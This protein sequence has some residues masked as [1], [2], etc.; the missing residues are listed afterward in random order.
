MPDRARHRMGTA[1]PVLGV[2]LASLTLLL[3]LLAAAPASAHAAFVASSPEP[4]AELVSAPG[5]VT[6]RFSEPL[7]DD[8]SSATVTDPAGQ[9]FTSGPS[10]DREIEVD[11]NSTTQGQYTVEWKTVSPIDGHTLRG[12]FSFGVGADVGHQDDASDLPTATDLAIGAARALEYAGLLGGL[13]LLTLA[14]AAARAR[15]PWAPRGLH[16]WVAAAALGGC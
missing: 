3:L 1:V 15:A 4:G 6:L 10:G 11:V 5:V 14:S 8:L 9:D 7:I 2:G 16:R 13:G 12:R